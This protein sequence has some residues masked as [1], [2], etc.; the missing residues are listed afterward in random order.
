MMILSYRFDVRLRGFLSQR[1]N[2]LSKAS[3]SE[4]A[5][6]KKTRSFKYV[7]L[8]CVTVMV[9][10]FGNDHKFLIS[11]KG[12]NDPEQIFIVTLDKVLSDIDSFIVPIFMLHWCVRNMAVYWTRERVPPPQCLRTLF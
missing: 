8:E 10:P 12:F 4:V 6:F 2:P 1:A 7:P 9:G 11:S 5:K 3:A